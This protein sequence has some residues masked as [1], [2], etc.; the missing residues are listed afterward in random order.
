MNHNYETQSSQRGSAMVK[1]LLILMIVVLTANAGVQ[2]VP[3]FYQGANLRQEM[4]AAVLKATTIPRTGFSSIDDARMQIEALAKISDLPKDAK[5][6]VSMN[7]NVV[8]AHIAFKK[9]VPVLPFG[10]YDYKYEFDHV[11]KPSSF[12]AN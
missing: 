3:V 8:T 1:M 2:L 5:V 6:E 11:A 9:K 10:F 4:N 7:N 12:S